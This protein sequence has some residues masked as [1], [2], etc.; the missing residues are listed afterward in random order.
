[1]AATRLA[2]MKLPLAS[3]TISIIA[4][5]GFA[6]SQHSVIRAVRPSSKKFERTNLQHA[7]RRSY[8][9]SAPE[10]K[11]RR[12]RHLRWLWRLTYLSTLAG[13]GWVAY[14][15]YQLRHPNV[16]V[17]PDPDKK[18]L[19][20]LGMIIILNWPYAFGYHRLTPL[21]RHWMGFHVPVEESRHRQ[22]QR[23]CY[24]A[25]QL[26]PLHSIAPIMHYWNNRT[27]VNHGADQEH[28]AS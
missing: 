12:F 18:T 24:L 2:S 21:N 28:S 27:S 13:V 9:D 10:K 8:A 7:F 14:D 3:S 17:D 4:R 20:I 5:R 1:M 25:A 23:R 22:V 16:Q 26:L 6:T 11:P 15:I 19:V